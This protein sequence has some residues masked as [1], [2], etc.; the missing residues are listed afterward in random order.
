MQRT[1]EFTVSMEEHR[2]AAN[3]KDRA[4]RGMFPRNVYVQRLLKKAESLHVLFLDSQVEDQWLYHPNY[5]ALCIW[6][7]DLGASSL[8]YLVMMLAHEL[9]HVLDFDAKPHYLRAIQGVPWFEVPWEIEL[10]AFVSGFRIIQELQIPVTLSQ[11]C[12]MIEPPMAK[13]VTRVIGG[14]QTLADA[15]SSS[16]QEPLAAARQAG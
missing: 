11:Y 15:V 6:L 4:V 10:S 12:Q 3:R 1:S 5:R 14:G 9:G 16:G 7:P 8:S 2:E 13:L